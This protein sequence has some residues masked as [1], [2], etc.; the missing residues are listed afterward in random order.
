MHEKISFISFFSQVLALVLS[1]TLPLTMLSKM[2]IFICAL[3]NKMQVRAKH[4]VE[5]FFSDEIA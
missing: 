3:E 5:S 2:L 4:I 1:V